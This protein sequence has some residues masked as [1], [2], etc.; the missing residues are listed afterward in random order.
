[1]RRRTPETTTPH[2]KVL[3]NGVVWCGLFCSLVAPPLFPP[4]CGV[5]PRN[6]CCVPSPLLSPSVPSCPLLLLLFF[7]S[8]PLLSPPVP[9]SS[10]PPPPPLLLLPSSSSSPPPPLLLLLLSCSSSPLLSPLV[11]SLSCLH[12]Q[13]P[14]SCVFQWHSQLRSFR[15]RALLLAQRNHD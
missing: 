14:S 1:M 9:S 5:V 6:Y 2:Q 8:S 12:L 11:P 7:S 15:G 4:Q 13:R 3:L 10:S